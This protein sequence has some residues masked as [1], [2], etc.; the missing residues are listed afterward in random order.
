LIVEAGEEDRETAEMRILAGT[1][2][3]IVIVI[4][5]GVETYTVPPLIQFH[6]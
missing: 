1:I 2:G 6:S 4:V 3:V 5:I